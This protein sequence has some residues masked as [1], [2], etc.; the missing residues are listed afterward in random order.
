MDVDT[1]YK[2]QGCLGYLLNLIQYETL[3]HVNFHLVTDADDRI[4]AVITQQNTTPLDTV[5]LLF[6]LGRL[7]TEYMEKDNP[8]QWSTSFSKPESWKYRNE[9]GVR[10]LLKR[11]HHAELNKDVFIVYWDIYLESS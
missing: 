2:A 8:Q 9:N 4:G 3:G 7:F 1:N 6:D 10:Q 11:L 5:A